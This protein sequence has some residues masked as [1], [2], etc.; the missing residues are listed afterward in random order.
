MRFFSLHFQYK[1]NLCT[2]IM[3]R[4]TTEQCV[5]AFPMTSTIVKIAIRSMNLF[6]FEPNR[7]V[8]KRQPNYYFSLDLSTILCSENQKVNLVN[9]IC[10]GNLSQ[11]VHS[12]SVLFSVRLLYF[13]DIR[14]GVTNT[15]SI[16]QFSQNNLQ[17]RTKKRTKKDHRKIGLY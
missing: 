9:C 5:D 3:K 7:L 15:N 6:L 16:R 10:H 14:F 13:I 1:T 12:C 11:N 17:F 8:I 4:N 2:Q